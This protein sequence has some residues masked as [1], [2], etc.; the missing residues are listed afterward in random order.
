MHARQYMHS[1][2]YI[3]INNSAVAIYT[4]SNRCVS[5][6]LTLCCKMRKPC[7]SAFRLSVCVGFVRCDAVLCCLVL[8][9]LD[10]S[11]GVL[12]CAVLVLGP[13]CFRCVVSSC[14]VLAYVVLVVHC[15]V[16]SCVAVSYVVLYYML[17][18][19]KYRHDT[20]V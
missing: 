3:Y 12:C 17:W 5:Y 8:S 15:L 4:K 10:L 6:A 7:S 13:C 19:K 16:L 2:I 18:P 20:S 11:C 1:Y 9:R 14:V